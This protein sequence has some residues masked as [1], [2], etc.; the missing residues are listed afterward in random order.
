MLIGKTEYQ[1]LIKISE[2]MFLKK[3]VGLFTA[4]LVATPIFAIDS[5]KL[6][7]SY[8]GYTYKQVDD[9]KPEVVYADLDGDKKD[10]AIVVVQMYS[11][12]GNDYPRSFAYIYKTDENKKLTNVLRAMPLNELSGVSVDDNEA[13][14]KIIEVMDLNNDG[15][16]EVALWSTGGMHYH[17]LIIVGMVVS[18]FNG[19]SENQIKYE[20]RKNKNIIIAGDIDN[21]DGSGNTHIWREDIWEWNGKEFVHSKEKSSLTTMPS[22]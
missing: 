14:D 10:E 13:H 7:Q 4:L 3:T 18:L 20:P 6:T 11:T 22:N 2:K 1:K 12:D 16:K 8:D 9:E 19:G 5:N 15:K 17:S 21:S